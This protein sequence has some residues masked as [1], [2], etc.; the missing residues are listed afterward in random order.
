MDQQARS[1]YSSFEEAFNCKVI[2]FTATNKSNF[3]FHN[4]IF[5]DYCQIK[6]KVI[7]TEIHRLIKTC[8][9]S[10]SDLYKGKAFDELNDAGV[11][12]I[13]MSSEMNNYD[14]PVTELE[15]ITPTVHCFVNAMQNI[16]WK[17][18]SK[19]FDELI[20]KQLSED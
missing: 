1:I 9:F 2:G 13:A 6:I 20:E 17:R 10:I 11:R 19:D 15:F 7:E 14:N 18:F 16:G 12:C 4:N 3:D 8:P 5:D